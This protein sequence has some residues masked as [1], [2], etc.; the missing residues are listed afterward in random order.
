MCWRSSANGDKL[1]AP[2][3]STM[4]ASWTWPISCLFWTTGAEPESAWCGDS[5]AA[6]WSPHCVVLAAALENSQGDIVLGRM[7]AEQIIIAAL[8][9][10]AVA[11][12]YSTVGHG[13]ASGYLAVMGWMSFSSAM[14]KPTALILNLVVAGMGTLR[15]HKA[16]A[17]RWSLFW[18]FVITSVPLA[19]L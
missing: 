1:A 4:M 8:A 3:I 19:Y 2:L 15:F 12:L 18:P 9:F 10:V 17:F 13:G 11:A 16:G 14:M 7:P 5:H 6:G